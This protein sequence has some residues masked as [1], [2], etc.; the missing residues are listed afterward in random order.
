ME[1]AT[2]SAVAG[3]VSCGSSAGTWEASDTIRIFRTP[4]GVVMAWGQFG[5]KVRCR[6]IHLLIYSRGI[7]QL[8]NPKALPRVHLFQL[9][10]SKLRLSP[11][12][13]YFRVLSRLRD[14]SSETTAWWDA[15]WTNGMGY[16]LAVEQSVYFF[17]RNIFQ[18]QITTKASWF[19]NNW[20]PWLH[21][22]QPLDL[23]AVPQAPDQKACD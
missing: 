6:N 19:L 10:I 22:Q 3:T 4:M 15:S 14:A 9:P 2:S 16:G 13:V 5:F 12:T 21:L 20:A 8:L 23:L 1:A 7:I 18:W 17:T 11:G